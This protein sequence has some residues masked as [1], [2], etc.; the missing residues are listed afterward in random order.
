MKKAILIL[1]SAILLTNCTMQKFNVD[2]CP[3]WTNSVKNPVNEEFI[4]EVAF[5]LKKQP[6]QVTQQ[7]FNNRY[8]NN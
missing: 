6:Q 4:N 3:K 5:N 2:A 7:E 1:S 8:V